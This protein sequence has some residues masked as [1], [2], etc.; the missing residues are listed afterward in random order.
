MKVLG[1][2]VRIKQ[3]KGRALKASVMMNIHENR[4]QGDQKKILS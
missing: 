1:S 3:G 4:A 2:G